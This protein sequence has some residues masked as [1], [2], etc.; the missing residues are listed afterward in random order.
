MVRCLVYK[1]EGSDKGKDTEKFI[2]GTVT[3]VCVS[4]A[5][6]NISTFHYR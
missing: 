2:R 4:F 1:I 5:Y 3:L 6:H